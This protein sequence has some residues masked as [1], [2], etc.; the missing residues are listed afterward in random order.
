MGF[1]PDPMSPAPAK[2]TALAEAATELEHWFAAN[3][4]RA[5][6]ACHESTAIEELNGALRNLMR[7]AVEKLDEAHCIDVLLSKP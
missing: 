3:R 5:A 6:A 2:A 4:P 1:E 7:R